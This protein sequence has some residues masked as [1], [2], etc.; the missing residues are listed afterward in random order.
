[1]TPESAASRDNAGIDLGVETAIALV[2]DICAKV[3]GKTADPGLGFIENG[4]DSLG[5]V[6]AAQLIGRSFTRDEP[7]E[8]DYVDL[9]E[10]PSLVE[11]AT[12]IVRLQ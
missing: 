11:V 5:A 3:I 10:C 9:L 4:G 1:M 6:R 8:F 7:I 2:T 12:L